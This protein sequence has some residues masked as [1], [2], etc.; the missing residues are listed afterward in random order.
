MTA[1][2]RPLPWLVIWTATLLSATQ[3][4]SQCDPV[5][6]E[7]STSTMAYRQRGDR[8]EGIYA[9]QV[10]AL[11]LQVRSLVRGFGP[12]DPAKNP[13]LTLEWKAPPNVSGD[14]H[15]RAFSFRPRTYFRMDTA[16]PA[17]RGL[18]RW[19]TDVLAGVGLSREDLGI[20]AW[21]DTPGS[22]F[23]DEV[24]LPLKIV[25]NEL[26]DGSTEIQATVVPSNRLE[27]LRVTIL[28][29]DEKG[30]EVGH[31]R[32]D[33]ELGYGYY[34]SNQQIEFPL[35]EAKETGFYKVKV[36]ARPAAESR[37]LAIEEFIFYLV[38]RSGSK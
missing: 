17:P 21:I 33:Q 13:H 14:V 29:L 8:C 23:G 16:V 1:S 34:P 31:L 38:Q 3:A 2:F 28:R 35:D 36:V 10:G 9:Q 15:I 20:V 30:R 27:E 37:D 5:L 22:G 7:R 18:Y 6:S 11:T 24:Y 4:Q 12:F 32:H 26:A 19:P 25:G